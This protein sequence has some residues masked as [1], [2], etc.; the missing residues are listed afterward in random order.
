VILQFDHAGPKCTDIGL[1]VEF[2]YQH[3]SEEGVGRIRNR[4]RHVYN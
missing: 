1:F 4:G 2:T 3:W